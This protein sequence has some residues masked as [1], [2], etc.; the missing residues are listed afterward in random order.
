[1]QVLD[2]FIKGYFQVNI[3]ILA[4]A[5]LFSVLY[6]ILISNFS[7]QSH[8]YF[9]EFIKNI[10]FQMLLIK[11]LL[12]YMLFAGSLLCDLKAIRQQKWSIF[13]LA[14]LGTVSSTAIVGIIT[15]LILHAFGI[16]TAITYCL[17]FGAFISPTDPIAVLDMLKFLNAPKK[18]REII[19]GESLFNDGVA[20]V[21]FITLLNIVNKEISTVTS[22]TILF[23]QSSFGGLFFGFILGWIAIQL[24]NL[25][26]K[27]NEIDILLTLW[28]TTTGY[29]L[30]N[31]LQ[32]SGPLAMVVSG[33]Y[34]GNY[35]TQ[36][37]K[38]A[39]CTFWSTI[40]HV[41]NAILFFLIGFE[42]ILYDFNSMNYLI[43]IILLIVCLFS[44]FISVLI[45]LNLFK[46]K[47]RIL[48]NEQIIIMFGG[49]KG[50][51]TIALS[52]LIP[53]S[54]EDFIFKITAYFLVVFSIIV[55]GLTI[56]PLMHAL[57][58]THSEK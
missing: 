57:D 11:Y 55:Q 27:E 50:G 21:I 47:P 8:L 37:R 33:I 40:D 53:A 36:T 52:F 4:C 28:I 25:G 14:F 56:K 34:I 6:K 19:A 32:V 31:H 12:S 58:Y 46:I 5:F 17:L 44:R 35:I 22:V 38:K 30:A 45:S 43:P 10:D 2:K 16:N 3:A 18:L 13:S 41:L 26:H 48:K 24:M 51:L 54:P 1:M 39:L 7:D 49:L 15:Y 29:W 23:I 9:Y 42:F 20:I